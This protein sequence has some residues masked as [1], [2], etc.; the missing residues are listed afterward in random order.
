MNIAILQPYFFPYMA[1]FQLIH[2]VD[3]FIFF[4]DVNFMKKKWINRNQIL[5][6]GKPCYFIVPLK[7]ISQNKLIRDVEIVGDE[8]WKMKI[9][10]SMELSYRRAPFFQTGFE[11]IETVLGQNHTHISLLAISSIKTVCSYLEIPTEFVDSSAGYL[12]TGLKAQERILDICRQEQ[13]SGYMN[14]I[15]GVDL[16]SKEVFQKHKI[17]L[18]FLKTDAAITY[19]QFKNDFVPY[20]SIIDLIMFNDLETIQ[21]FLKKFQ[22]V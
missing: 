16:Y 4:D 12:N 21:C 13:A 15:G 18:N 3:K 6:S 22:T 10:R 5:I 2:A 19:P 8:K 9:L 11:L 7:K 20:L 17:R 1:Y 14:P